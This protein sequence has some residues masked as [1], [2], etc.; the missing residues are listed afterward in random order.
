MF[1][2]KNGK[3]WHWMYLT[4]I[5]GQQ[6]KNRN[7][8][9]RFEG[10]LARERVDAVQRNMHAICQRKRNEKCGKE[11]SGVEKSIRQLSKKSAL[12]DVKPYH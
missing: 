5:A 11:E 10:Y 8:F 1:N 2:L 7:A 6:G 12:R 9:N 3:T 4:I